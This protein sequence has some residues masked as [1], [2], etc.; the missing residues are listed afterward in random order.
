MASLAASVAAAQAQA[1]AEDL[2]AL[3]WRHT[4]IGSEEARDGA[5]ETSGSSAAADAGKAR[6]SLG[7]AF[8]ATLLVSAAW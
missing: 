7:S 8:D 4:V 2:R 1:E 5:S 3:S 6:P